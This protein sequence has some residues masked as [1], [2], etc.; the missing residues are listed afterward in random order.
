MENKNFESR[1]RARSSALKSFR[2]KKL[3]GRA[4]GEYS[5]VRDGSSCHQLQSV[6]FRC[7]HCIFA[8]IFVRGKIKL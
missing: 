2:G 5:V 8:P 7:I 6:F 3:R 4:C 1:A